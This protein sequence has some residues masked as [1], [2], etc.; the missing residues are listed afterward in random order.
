V[1]SISISILD[2]VLDFRDFILRSINLNLRAASLSE[3]ASPSELLP[4]SLISLSPSEAETEAAEPLEEVSLAL[5]ADSDA[6]VDADVDVN[7]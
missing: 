2:D 6:I 3:D 5:T 1:E 7:I 4:E